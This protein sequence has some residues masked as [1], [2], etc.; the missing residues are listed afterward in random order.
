MSAHPKIPENKTFNVS[1]PWFSLI[2]SGQKSVEGRLAKSRFAEI[3]VGDLLKWTNS[4]QVG[5]DQKPIV[6]EFITRVS[7]IVYYKD[8]ETYLAKERLK[9]CLPG[10]RTIKDGVAVY[11]KFYPKEERQKYKVMAIHLVVLN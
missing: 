11:H 3:Q 1:E 7:A 8:F 10:V 5:K 2:Q 4:D 9:N 6:R